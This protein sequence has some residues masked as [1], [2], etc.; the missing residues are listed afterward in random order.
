LQSP[1]DHSG[2]VTGRKI[3]LIAGNGQFPL[4]FARAAR[5]NRLSV[6]AVA[7]IGETDSEL[8]A[9]VDAIQ[10]L[11]V[12]QIKKLIR[13][14]RRSGIDVAVMICGIRKTR[15]FTDVRPDTKAIALFAAMKHTH[16]DGILRAFAEVLEKA[17]I[18]VLPSTD[19]VPELLAAEGCWTRRR[20][21]RA[22]KADIELGWKLA[23]EIGRLGIGQCVVMGGGSVLAVEAI[24]GTDATIARGAGLGKGNAVVV[25]ICKPNQD[26]RFD[27]PAVGVET[28]EI[29][30]AHGAT[31][32]AV[33]AGRTVV[34]DRE[35]MIA[36]ADA[37][38]IAIVA[39]DGVEN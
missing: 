34:F 31:A 29:M 25:K 13:F 1:L 16:D 18:R 11:H 14:F 30:A 23:K 20:P 8:E 6:R 24:D 7:H 39:L 2:P 5:K 36:A 17:G 32:L 9:H 28:I 37:A 38:G 15:M 35:K 4:I 33:E 19:L 26:L 12:G 27:I 10:W 22:E 3:G 21:G